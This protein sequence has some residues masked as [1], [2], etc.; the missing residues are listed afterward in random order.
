MEAGLAD[1]DSPQS[2]EGTLLHEYDANPNLDRSFLK[3]SQRDL[4]STATRLDEAVFERA[5]EQFGA[6]DNFE[7]GREEDLSVTF[8]AWHIGVENQTGVILPGHCDRR[9]YYP[10]LKLLVVIDKKFGF[11]EVTPAAANPQLRAYALGGGIKYPS[12]NIVVAITQPRLSFERRITMANYQPADIA[13]ALVEVAAILENARKP[14]APLV[15]GPEQCRYCKAKLTCGAYRDYV[16]QGMSVVAVLS[17]TPA[18]RGADAAEIIKAA[19]DEQLDRLLVAIQMADFVSD[20]A[21][22]EGRRRVAA[23]QLTTWK[24]GKEGEQRS[25][26]DAR[27]AISFLRLNGRLSDE[28]IFDCA[29]LSITQVTEKYREKTNCSWKEAKEFI[30]FCLGSVIVLEPKRASLS[31]IK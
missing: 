28:A 9:R 6:S 29:K 11:D 1:D 31:R 17:G 13:A 15:P 23:G 4:L 12:D 16:G 10:D 7:E 27:R 24:I 30:D 20:I 18:K 25:I 26:V 21:K 19:T 14:D 2:R 5:K 3:P 22:D 8:G